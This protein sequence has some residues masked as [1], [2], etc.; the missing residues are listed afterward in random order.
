MMKEMKT[1]VRVP[2]WLGTSYHFTDHMSG[3]SRGCNKF[4]EC[5]RVDSAEAE[6]IYSKDQSMNQQEF[7]RDGRMMNDDEGGTK[8]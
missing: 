3:C 4:I 8:R 2:D 6:V 5:F 1:M 7:T